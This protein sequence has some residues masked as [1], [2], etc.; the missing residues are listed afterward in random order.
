MTEVVNADDPI[1]DCV[2]RLLLGQIVATVMEGVRVVEV[3]R[4]PLPIVAGVAAL[5]RVRPSLASNR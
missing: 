4:T 5:R 3:L 2:P 1:R